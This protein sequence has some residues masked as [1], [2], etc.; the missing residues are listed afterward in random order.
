[1]TT[2]HLTTAGAGMRHLG[3]GVGVVGLFPHPDARPSPGPG[4]RVPGMA[5][6]NG[7]YDPAG[8]DPSSAVRAAHHGGT[9]PTFTP[10][11]E[12]R[13]GLRPLDADEKRAIRRLE[14]AL[15]N[16]PSNMILVTTGDARLQVVDAI[17]RNLPL[18]DGKAR[19]LGIVLAD[20]KSGCQIAGVSG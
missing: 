17:G 5:G 11:N 7:M 9:M 4:T 20:I 14:R 18:H 15:L 3:R 1:M 6:D 8:W 16:M 10:N 19:E 13:E 12:L 2:H